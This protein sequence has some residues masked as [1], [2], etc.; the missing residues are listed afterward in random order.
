MVGPRTHA[1]VQ[2]PPPTTACNT[3]KTSTSTI[4]ITNINNTS[5]NT[6]ININNINIKHVSPD[7]GPRIRVAAAILARVA[8]GDCGVVL[9]RAV[10]V[11]ILVSA[12]GRVELDAERSGKGRSGS[13]R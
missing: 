2:V 12:R 5:T 7:V 6:D 4:T 9:E 1:Y 10:D 11:P 3:G 13:E 8:D